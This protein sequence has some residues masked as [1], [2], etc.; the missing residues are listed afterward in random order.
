MMDSM[1]RQKGKFAGRIAAGQL[2]LL[3]ALGMGAAPGFA[4]DMFTKPTPEELAMTSAPGIPGAPALVLFDEEITKDDLHVIQHY[5]R[6]K[7]LTQEGVDNYANVELNYVRTSGNDEYVGNEETVGDITART[8]HADGTIIPFTGKPYLKTIV[9]GQD[10]KF[11]SMVFTLPDVQVGSIIEYRYATRYNDEVY[12]APDWIIQGDL[13]V[14][15]AHYEWFPT[16]KP[17]VDPDGDKPINAISWFPILPAGAKINRIQAPGDAVNP[18]HEYYDLVIHDVPPQPKEEHMPPIANY[19]Y[20]VL[21]NFTAY[22]S[23]ADFWKSTGK[24][25]SKTADTFIGPNG[26]LKKATQDVIAGATT[27]DEKLHKI[28]A[29]VMALEN[30]NY[31]RVRDAREEKAEG[32]GKVDNADEI[33]KHKRGNDSELTM[34]FVGMARA[35]GLEG[36]VMLVPNRN[37]HFFLENWLSLQQFDDTIAVVNV[38][39]KDVYFDPGSR[40]C[41]YEHLAWQH[42]FVE[43]LRQTAS[44]TEFAQTLGDGYGANK[45]TRVANLTMDEHGEIKGRIDLEFNGAGALDWRH[46]ALRGDEES[47]RHGLEEHLQALVPKSLEVKVSEIKN[48]DDYEQPL[49]VSYDVTGTMGTPTGKRLVMPV[50]LFTAGETATF[51]Q[52]KRDTAVYFHYPESVLDAQRVNFKPGFEV[53]ATPTEGKF[54]IPKR[55]M[56]DLTSTFGPTNFTTRRTFVIGDFLFMP[57]DYSALRDFYSQFEAKDQESVVL[58]MVPVSVGENSQVDSKKAN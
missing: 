30:T 53:E 52:T 56:Y 40:Y 6:V 7:I 32:G 16:S 17:L 13:Y 25:W 18:A 15:S 20:R 46:R 19:G 55:A 42:S 38:D 12:E 54:T 35:A 28:Y 24:H 29:A 22:T 26:D 10:A 33:L 4:A 45:A 51:P 43:G 14:K 31:T 23:S 41:A 1:K 34:L 2:L 5:K 21:F 57:T 49:K 47:L 36:Y 3:A 8:I 48:L 11:Q 27:P 9:K 58:K 37:E 50:D 44:G 39:G